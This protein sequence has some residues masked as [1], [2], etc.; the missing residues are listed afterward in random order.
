MRAEALTDFADLREGVM[1]SKGER[2]E[3]SA[4]RFRQLNATKY[5]QLVR[6]VRTRKAKED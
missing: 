1:R 5:G 4:E 2:F 3:V 6:E